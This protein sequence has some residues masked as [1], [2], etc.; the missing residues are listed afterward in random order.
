MTNRRRAIKDEDKQ[1][2]RS[3]I[4]DIAW[5]LFQD[6]SYQAVTMSQVAER[7]RLAK[8]TIYLYFN[9]KEELF[10][11]LQNRQLRA[12]FDAIDAW[13]QAAPDECS[14]PQVAGMIC[15]ALEERPALTRLLAIL[16]TVLEQNIDFDTAFQF[17]QMQLDRIGHTGALLEH[18]L[19]FLTPGQGKRL[20]LHTLALVIGLR[21]LADPAPM[22]RR[23]M[24]E[25]G[26]E[27][28]AVDFA[29]E[30]QATFTALL[31][32]LREAAASDMPL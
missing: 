4:L 17:K 19:P 11:A 2:R 21:H 12:W 26:M 6:A 31:L 14:I 27:V 18:R 10:L 28:F 1:Q 22:A 23:V 30:F 24:K 5:E 7:A 3:A 25:P 15:G 20:L 32:G 8:G 13:L 9:T 16:H 29:H